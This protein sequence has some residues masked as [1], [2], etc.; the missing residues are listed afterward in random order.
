[1]PNE[2]EPPAPTQQTPKGHE[3]PVPKREA[4]MDFFK[5]VTGKRP[6]PPPSEDSTR[7]G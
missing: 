2:R 5:G 6:A 1:M 3:I 7:K 4:V